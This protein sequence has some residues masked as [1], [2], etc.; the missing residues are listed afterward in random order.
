MGKLTILLA[1]AALA[2]AHTH[3]RGFSVQPAANWSAQNNEQGVV[4]IPTGANSQEEVYVA[5]VQEGYSAAEEARTVQQLSQTFL[6]NGAQIRRAGERE[7]IGNGAAYYWEMVDPNTRQ[8]AGL[9]IY[10]TPV[11]AR[12]NVIIAFGLANRIAARDSDLR[13]MLTSLR[14]AAPAQTGGLADSTALAEQWQQKLQGKMIR[15]FHAYQG[16]SSDKRHMLNADGTYS[17]HSDSVVAIDVAGASA[18]SIGNR[19]AQGRWHIRDAGGVVFLDVRYNNGE[20]RQFRI[21]QDAHNW[22]LNGE[23][24]FAVNP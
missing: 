5:A 20:T 16:M 6:R 24:A 12:A 14:T 21:T 13:S 19:N 22:Y 10:F 17:F 7:P 11:G 15:Q 1:T 18:S 9:R 4:L 23:K 8:V 2:F 3:P